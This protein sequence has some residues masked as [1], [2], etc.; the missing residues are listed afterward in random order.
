MM[1]PRW[2]LTVF[3]LDVEL[4]GYLLVGQT[5]AHQAEDLPFAEGEVGR[6]DEV[7]RRSRTAAR[8]TPAHNAATRRAAGPVGAR[9]APAAV[10]PAGFTQGTARDGPPPAPPRHRPLRPRRTGP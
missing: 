7:V 1:A 4:L 9:S 6:F 2:F 5:L 8:S 10:G 3:S